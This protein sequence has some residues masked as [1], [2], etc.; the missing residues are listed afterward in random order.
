MKRLKEETDPSI[1]HIDLRGSTFRD[2]SS[3]SAALIE[4]LGS[5]HTNG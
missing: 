2:V 4:E 5:W 3:F 1:V